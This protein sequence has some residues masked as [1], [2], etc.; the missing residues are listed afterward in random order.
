MLRFAKPTIFGLTDSCLRR[1]E[2]QTVYEDE[3]Y[4]IGKTQVQINTADPHFARN[5]YNPK[6]SPNVTIG[7]NNLR[8]YHAFS[9]RFDAYTTLDYTQMLKGEFD[10][11]GYDITTLLNHLFPGADVQITGNIEIK[12]KEK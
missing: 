2:A 1:S 7:F 9:N 8:I 11:A 12:V 5:E 3:K 6:D 10:I 4:V